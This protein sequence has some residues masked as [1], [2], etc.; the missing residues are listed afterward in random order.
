MSSRGADMAIVD[1]AKN[2]A[3]ILAGY[4][5]YDGIEIDQDHVIQWADQFPENI[6]QRLLDVVAATF[7]RTYFSER[8]CRALLRRILNSSRLTHGDPV[9]YWSSTHVLRNQV[10]GQ[11]Q[12]RMVDI[13]EA[14]AKTQFGQEFKF[15]EPGASRYFYLDDF[16]FSGGRVKEDFA[17]WLISVE[18]Q[19]GPIH[20]DLGYFGVHAL[21]EFFFDQYAEEQISRFRGRITY[22]VRR[23]MDFENRRTRRNSSDV[24]WPVRQAESVGY[25]E[26]DTGNIYLRVPPGQN[27]TFSTETD[28]NFLETE[29]LR[30]GCKI[31]SSCAVRAAGMKPLGF[32]NFGYGFGAVC[33]TFMNCPNNAPLALWWTANTRDLPNGWNALIP[34]RVND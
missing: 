32:Y 16:I 22:K 5:D 12:R 7:S 28:R 18:S 11:S 8:R 20:L 14:M 27:R 6:R 15:A 23:H 2:L 24:L 1:S 19:D 33:S 34:R 26:F 30:A 3:S 9:G 4:R 10:R 21:G 25:P 17:R 13:F 31:A 29:L